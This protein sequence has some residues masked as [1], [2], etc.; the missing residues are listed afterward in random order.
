MPKETVIYKSANG[1]LWYLLQE[2]DSEWMRVRH[3]PN[4][5]SGGRSSVMELN[6]FL[7]EGHGPQH[8]AL[9]RL[10]LLMESNSTRS[11]RH[12]DQAA[13]LRAMAAREP[14]GSTIQEQ[15]LKLA[16]EYDRLAARAEGTVS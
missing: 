3:Q 10:L 13:Q 15:V 16:E 14:P 2:A 11:Q 6:A 8:E 7:S 1:D 12:R 4:R 5:A 9:L